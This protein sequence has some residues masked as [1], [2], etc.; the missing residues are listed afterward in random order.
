MVV[1]LMSL[2]WKRIRTVA[3]SLLALLVLL[4][5]IRR[6]G[7][8]GPQWSAEEVR[9]TVISTI[10]SEAPESFLV[11]GTLN[12]SATATITDTKYLLPDI[13]RLNL[14]T[15]EAVVRLPGRVSYGF[16][17][18][19]LEEEDIEVRDDG[20]VVVRLPD[21]AVH[22][23]EP[24]LARMEVQ[25]TVGWARL[26]R[27]SGRHAEREAVTAAADALRRQGERHLADALQPRVNTATALEKLLIPVLQAAGIA[28]PVVRFDGRDAPALHRI[29]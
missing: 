10:Q 12:L 15:T 18:M 26:Y 19:Q 21:L 23:V 25:T 8:L 11:T 1:A 4:L 24:D 5:M 14:G 17:V 6:I 9:R 3:V 20:T 2:P 16:D 27:S 22:A 7:G 28:D 29:E 13:L